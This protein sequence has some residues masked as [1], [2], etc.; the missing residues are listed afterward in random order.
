MIE[1]HWDC[2]GGVIGSGLK[3]KCWDTRNVTASLDFIFDQPNDY[4]LKFNKNL[5]ST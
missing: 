4:L 3:S 2:I 1:E 5:N